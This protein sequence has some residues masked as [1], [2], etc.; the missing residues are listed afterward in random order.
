MHTF[1]ASLIYKIY[2]FVYTL[3][4]EKITDKNIYDKTI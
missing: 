2:I 4:I 1:N 3:S